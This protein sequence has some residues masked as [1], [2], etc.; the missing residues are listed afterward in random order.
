[1]P[2][3]VRRPASAPSWRLPTSSCAATSAWRALQADAPRPLSEELRIE[4]GFELA[5]AAALGGRLDAALVEDVPGA[6]RILDRAGPEG[7]SALLAA[8]LSGS[9]EHRARAAAGAGARR[10]TDLLSGPAEVLELARRLLADAWVVDRLEDVPSRLR[11]SPRP[12][13]AGLVRSVGRGPPAERRRHRAVL[14]RRNERDRLIAEVERAAQAEHAA[15]SA[16]SEAPRASA[17]EAAPRARPRCA[18]RGRARCAEARRRVRRTRVADRAAPRGAGRRARW[19]CAGPS[20]RASS[21]PSA[22]RPSAAA[23]R[24]AAAARIERL[25]AQRT[26]DA[27]LAPRAE[28]LAGAIDGGRAAPSPSA[29]RQLETELAADRQAGEEMAR[30]AARCA[31]REA[32]IQAGCATAGERVTEA[33]VAAQ[34]LRDQAA[35]A[36]LELATRRRA[37]GPRRIARGPDGRPGLERAGPRSCTRASSA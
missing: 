30:R 31:A 25:R 19:R 24:R 33:E 9:P 16:L 26:A 34:R 32:E 6:Q 10:L 29:S 4:D 28:R 18:A 12:A 17:A 35:E 8:G 36:E 5:L 15:P 11:A 13:R 23:E 7:G 21:P 3:A 22:G 14:A 27:A 1:M 2:P 20:S 37:A